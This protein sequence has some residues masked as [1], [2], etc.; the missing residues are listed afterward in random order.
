[1]HL[2][3]I[4]APA[5]NLIAYDDDAL[6]AAEAQTLIQELLPLLELVVA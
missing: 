3:L 5:G 6:P 1:M 4:A 2:S